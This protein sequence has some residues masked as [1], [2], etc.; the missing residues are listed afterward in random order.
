MSGGEDE[1]EDDQWDGQ[2]DRGE[3][4]EKVRKGGTRN[5]GSENTAN[6]NNLGDRENRGRQMEQVDYGR[7]DTTQLQT[8]NVADCIHP[9]MTA[10]EHDP[11]HTARHVERDCVN[12]LGTEERTCVSEGDREGDGLP[13]HPLVTLYKQ[14]QQNGRYNAI[15]LGNEE[16][17]AGQIEKLSLSN[18]CNLG[19]SSDDLQSTAKQS[20]YFK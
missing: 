10:E 15:V 1:N 8:R 4:K 13:E 20:E 9:S 6:T 17:L 2:R 3:G 16:A 7:G 12:G 18:Y 19:E 5:K 14:Q 11:L